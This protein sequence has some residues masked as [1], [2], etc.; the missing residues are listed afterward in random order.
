MFKSFRVPKSEIWS[1]ITIGTK[2]VREEAYCINMYPP[3]GLDI[4]PFRIELGDLIS[5]CDYSDMLIVRNIII[6]KPGEIRLRLIQ[7]MDSA[8]EGHPFYV[9]PKNVLK[10]HFGIEKDAAYRTKV[11]DL[12]RGYG[13]DQLAYITSEWKGLSPEQ[14]EQIREQATRHKDPNAML[15]MLF[16]PRKRGEE[17]FMIEHATK[18]LSFQPPMLYTDHYT[19]LTI[20][21]QSKQMTLTNRNIVTYRDSNGTVNQGYVFSMAMNLIEDSLLLYILPFTMTAKYPQPERV[22][23]SDILQIN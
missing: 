19:S 13:E 5:I 15:N 12:M 22:Q 23:P 17:P 7:K 16:T 1:R 21:T 6:E 3:A 4:K 2:Y 11:L 10:K 14:K 20:R 18:W 9:S 8:L